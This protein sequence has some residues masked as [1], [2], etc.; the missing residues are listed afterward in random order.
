MVSDEDYEW[1]NQWKWNYCKIGNGYYPARTGY[2]NGKKTSIKMHRL[3]IGASVNDGKLI[4]HRDGN[5]MNCQRNNLRFIDRSGNAM[6]TSSRKGSSSK[7]LG[8]SWNT[9]EKM[10]RAQIN[11]KGKRK[12]L[13]RYKTEEA[14]AIK[15]NEFAAIHYEEF[16][17][18]NIIPT[19][20]PVVASE[21]LSLNV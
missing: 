12:Y 20:P 5:T 17:R 2:E 16:A 6:N 1:L 4:D 15:Y 10:W 8:V 9:H 19:Q 13:G 21:G 14:A 3:I 18:L 11:I 7:Y